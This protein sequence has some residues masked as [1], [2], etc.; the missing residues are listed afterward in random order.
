MRVS[1]RLI[2]EGTFAAWAAED[3]ATVAA[4][5]HDD[6]LYVLHLP[7]HAWPIAGVV[8]GKQRVM[9]SLAAF[10]RDFD[11]VEYRP[12]KIRVE[13][14]VFST[15]ARLHYAHKRTGLCYEATI[16]NRGRLAGGKIAYFEV[17]HDTA[18]LR[19]FYDMVRRMTVEA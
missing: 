15:R 13:D 7:E 8:R 19:A 12:L 9:A 14:G 17:L 18:R 11:V 2:V 6:S 10:L 3:L 4:S 1:E 5:V 16:A